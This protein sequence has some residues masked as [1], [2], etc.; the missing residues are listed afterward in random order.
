[1]KRKDGFI[2]RELAGQNIVLAVGEASKIFRGMIKLN[3]TGL[4]IWE[5]LANDVSEEQIVDALIESYEVERERASADV[6]RFVS[7]LA[8]AGIIE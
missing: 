5:M 3:T 1:M 2:V 7:L 6:R 8:E 4:F